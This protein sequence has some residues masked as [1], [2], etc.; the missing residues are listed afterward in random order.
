MSKEKIV[1]RFVDN[2]SKDDIVELYKSGSWWKD[3]WNTSDMG[4]PGLRKAKMAYRP[5]NM[6]EVFYINKEDVKL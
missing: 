4:V 2:W 1:I 3:S 6:I 5:D